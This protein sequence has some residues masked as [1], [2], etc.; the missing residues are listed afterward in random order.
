MGLAVKFAKFTDKISGFLGMISVYVT[1]ILVFVGIMN[2]L[3]RYIGEA[4]GTKLVNNM[5]IETQWYL[6][7]LIFLLAFAFNMRDGVNVR[8]DFWYAEQSP[9]T[10][11][12]IDLVG[13]V[14]FLIPFCLLAL[15]VTW[16]PVLKSWGQLPDGTFGTWE[17]SPDPNG[18]PRAPIKSMV[19][20]A[21]FTLLMQTFS[22]LI[23]LIAILR[24][25]GHLFAIDT[26]GVEAP[27][28]I[29]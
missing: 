16:G 3:L 20:V 13:H 28:R 25:Q 12:W 17:L 19:L 22:E 9:K 18:L 14:L 4:I 11:A 26:D 1:I 21:F 5:F 29:E 24:D 8:V 27:V 6:Y 15:N 23:K 2:V 10:K 7:T